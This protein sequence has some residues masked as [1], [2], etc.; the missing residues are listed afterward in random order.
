MNS[1]WVP[2]Q[3]ITCRALALIWRGPELLMLR[4]NEE[5]GAVTG[6]RP[7]GGGI[8]FGET[9]EQAIYREIQEELGTA[10]LSER[11][12]GFVENIYQMGGHQGHEVLALWQGKVA[13]HTVYEQERVPYAE[14]HMQAKGNFMVWKD[15]FAA[16]L[17]IFPET[18]LPLLKEVNHA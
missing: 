6:Y 3:R 10:F 2:P 16:E 7:I 12:L 9:S 1:M 4:V 14:P 5:H 18:M 8:E 11:F 15:P 17:P 13:D